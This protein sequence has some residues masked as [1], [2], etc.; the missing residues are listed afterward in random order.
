[1]Y[2]LSLF[3]PFSFEAF[4]YQGGVDTSIISVDSGSEITVPVIP[5]VFIQRRSRVHVYACTRAHQPR[6]RVLKKRIFI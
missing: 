6:V 4:V 3:H 5:G 2:V 1:M